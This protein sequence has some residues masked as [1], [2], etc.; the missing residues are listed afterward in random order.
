MAIYCEERADLLAVCSF[1][2]VFVCA[3]FLFNACFLWYCCLP[4]MLCCTI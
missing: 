2:F 1:F 3:K 4:W